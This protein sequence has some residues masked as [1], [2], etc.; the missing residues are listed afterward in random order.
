LEH[1]DSSRRKSLRLQRT[2]RAGRAISLRE[3][4]NRQIELGSR[5]KLAATQFSAT[6]G[7]WTRFID[8]GG[9]KMDC[10][11]RR[12]IVGTVQTEPGKAG[13]TGAISSAAIALP[14]LG[15]A[16]SCRKKTLPPQR[17]PARVPRFE[18]IVP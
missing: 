12:R 10:L 16:G 11:G 6:A 15:R 18:M 14:L 7:F 5:R 17:R 2:Q 4:A 1:A 9:W 3:F 8:S 13:R